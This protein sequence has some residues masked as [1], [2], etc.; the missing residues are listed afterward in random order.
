MKKKTI[1]FGLI[2]V[3]AA[4]I[5]FYSAFWPLDRRS[6]LQGTI[7]GV[8]KAE[9]YRGEQM[10]VSEL[11]LENEE[12]TQFLQSAEWQNAMKNEDLINFLKSDEFKSFIS[13]TGDMQKIVL[14]N[15]YFDTVKLSL[16]KEADLN[17]EVINLFFKNNDF[18]HFVLSQ[19]FMNWPIPSTPLNQDFQ[20]LTGSAFSQEFQK[21]YLA[22][23]SAIESI[24]FA[25]MMKML[26]A[27]SPSLESFFNLDILGWVNSQD[28]ESFIASME[29]KSFVSSQDY[30]SALFSQDFQNILISFSQDFQTFNI[31]QMNDF[32]G[33]NN[34]DFHQLVLSREF[35][36]ILQN[37]FF[38]EIWAGNQDFQQNMLGAFQTI[39]TGR[40]RRNILELFHL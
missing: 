35:Q 37:D 15:N 39:C 34:Q 16:L 11:L 25:S 3:V 18:Q 17:E 10:A 19:D 30:Q 21:V 24:E 6:G 29:Y 22:N 4:I 2:I 13:M 32:I 20:S 31:K 26:A 27:G 8:E 33:P 40:V 23:P 14:L 28:F 12:F 38:G 36:L 9:K 7:G 5:I 1:F